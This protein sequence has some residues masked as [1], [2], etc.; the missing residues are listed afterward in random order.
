MALGIE[1]ECVT[2]ING[3]RVCSIEYCCIHLCMFERIMGGKY[4]LLSI[5]ADLYN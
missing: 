1:C 2:V 3:I 4:Q 5:V